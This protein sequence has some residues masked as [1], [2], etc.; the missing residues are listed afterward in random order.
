VIV[1]NRQGA[2]RLVNTKKQERPQ[3]RLAQQP[4]ESSVGEHQHRTNIGR[5]LRTIDRIPSSAVMINVIIMQMQA[6]D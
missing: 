4:T 3:R 2:L 1:V 6:A 5:I